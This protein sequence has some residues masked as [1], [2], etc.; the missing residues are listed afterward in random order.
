MTPFEILFS[1]PGIIAM[2]FLVP[3]ALALIIDGT[4]FLFDTLRDSKEPEELKIW[5]ELSKTA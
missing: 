4:V 3:C 5:K 1:I 2:T